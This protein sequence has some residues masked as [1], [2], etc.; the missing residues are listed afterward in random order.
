MITSRD[1][2]EHIKNIY[3][4]REYIDTLYYV[5]PENIDINKIIPI[6]EIKNNWAKIKFIYEYSKNIK[7]KLL[8]KSEYTNFYCNISNQ[9]IYNFNIN[10]NSQE[11][12]N[13]GIISY[14]LDKLGKSMIEKNNNNV[15]KINGFISDKFIKCKLAKKFGSNK[16]KIIIYNKDNT[17]EEFQN[18]Y[19]KKLLYKLGRMN[20]SNNYNTFKGKYVVE[21]EINIGP[22]NDNQIENN[23]QN[24]CYYSNYKTHIVEIKHIRDNIESKIDKS[25]IINNND[26]IH[27][28]I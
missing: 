17:S 23:E 21:P 9:E 26:M 13:L 27:I 19:D 15:N 22:F 25:A 11:N 18:V 12:S 1:I 14:H 3:S 2:K 7:K 8:I 6:Y 10:L 4:S 20:S 24:L 28:E 16:T 5:E